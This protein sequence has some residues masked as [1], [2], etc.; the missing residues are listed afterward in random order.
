MEQFV[1]GYGSL[2][3]EADRNRTIADLL[4]HQQTIISYP[5]IVRG[6]QRGWWAHR[7]PPGL[8]TTFLAI[9]QDAQSRCNGVIFPV[10]DEELSKFDQREKSYQR[11][12]IPFADVEW[13]ATQSDAESATNSLTQGVIWA[14]F[15]KAEQDKIPD[16]DYPIV[17]SYIDI[18]LTGC[19]EIEEQFFEAKEQ[20]FAE[21]FI[22]LTED[23][24]AHWVNDRLYP[25]RPHVY[26]PR[27]RQID[28]LLASA[29]PT[30]DLFPNVKIE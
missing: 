28:R 26:V 16:S 25:R 14:Y 19:L 4:D 21:L 29:A 15:V 13:F 24:N 7:V 17:Q 27:A 6:M 8:G 11:V 18:C 1:F 30:K 10:S 9:R 3:S 12:Q 5:A 23:W 22:D 20:S 2:I